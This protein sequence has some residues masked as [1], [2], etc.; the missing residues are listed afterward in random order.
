MLCLSKNKL[1]SLP[2][3]LGYVNSLHMLKADGNPLQFPAPEV[4]QLP[5]D[6]PVPE[7]EKARDSLITHQVKKHMRD[8]LSRTTRDKLR[9][10]SEEDSYRWVIAYHG[11]VCPHSDRM[12]QRGQRRYSSAVQARCQRQKIPGQAQSRR[13][14]RRAFHSAKGQISKHHCGTADTIALRGKDLVALQRHL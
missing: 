7:E 3:S 5:G 11:F 10:E 1:K 12:S 9:V 6:V 4:W 14:R 13:R 2:P 8:T